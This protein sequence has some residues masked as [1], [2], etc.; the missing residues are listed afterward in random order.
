[1]A[2]KTAAALWRW[3]DEGKL[4]VVID[5]SS[6]A[7]GLLHEVPGALGE[8]AAERHGRIEILDSIAW[9]HDRL[10]PALDVRPAGPIAVHPTCST[11]HLGMTAKLEALAGALGEAYVPP[12]AFCCGF[13][14]DRGMLHPELT[15]S[16]TRP[17]A[18][19][20]AARSFDAFV[21][22][23][24]TCE[25]GMTSGTGNPYVSIVQL[26]EERSR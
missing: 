24:R 26:L 1:M 8:E 13:A 4:P 9:A 23:N 16:A 3:S 11:R 10:L 12:S 25:I 21:S 2:R 17:E 20:V 14:G 22:S 18:E 7:G 19:E 5:A 6:C 15:A